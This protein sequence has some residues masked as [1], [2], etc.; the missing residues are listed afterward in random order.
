MDHPSERFG[1]RMGT[2]GMMVVVLTLDGRQA[3]VA[4][5]VRGG[6]RADDA[7]GPRP[8]GV[9]IQALRMMDTSTINE[10]T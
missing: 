8:F 7:T 1:L 2:V 3:G 9:A 4:A 6:S 10:P 5:A